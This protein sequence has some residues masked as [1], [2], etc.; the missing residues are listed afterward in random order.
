MTYDTYKNISEAYLGAARSACSA[1]S[2]VRYT[3][4]LARLYEARRRDRADTVVI[5]Y[6]MDAYLG[7][8]WKTSGRR[9]EFIGRETAQGERLVVVLETLGIPLP[10]GWR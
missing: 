7:G 6:A 5:R 8:F 10:G 3:P 4:S 1:R 2:V 9:V